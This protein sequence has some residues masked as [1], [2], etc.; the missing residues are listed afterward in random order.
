VPIAYIVYRGGTFATLGAF[1]AIIVLGNQWNEKNL[2]NQ[3]S[4]K[5]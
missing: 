1:G 3:W 2:S 5:K 4:V